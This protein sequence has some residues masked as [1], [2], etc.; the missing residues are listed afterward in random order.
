M[1]LTGENQSIQR[2]TRP[3]ANLSPQNQQ[4]LGWNQT[5]GVRVINKKCVFGRQVFCFK[6]EDCNYQ[7]YDVCGQLLYR[8]N[9]D[10]Y[11]TIRHETGKNVI[12]VHNLMIICC[13][14]NN[15]EI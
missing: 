9:E 1:I 10:N 5:S 7:E 8:H 15:S 2:K 14:Q 13:K 6:N 12:Y 3:S 4:S 11:G